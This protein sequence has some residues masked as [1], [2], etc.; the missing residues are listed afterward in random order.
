MFLALLLPLYAASLDNLEIGGPWGTPA[1]TDATAVWWNPAGL[2][3][4]EGTRLMVEVAP[5]IATLSYDRSDPGGGQDTYK[6][7]APV[8][9]AGVATDFGVE[10]LGFG[11]A[12][13][14]PIAR[15]AA[16]QE[17]TGA[18]R[19]ALREGEIKAIYGLVGAG[20]SYKDLVAVGAS[21]AVVQSSWAGVVDSVLLPDLVTEI[22]KLGEETHYT[23]ADI[24]DPDYAATLHLD[25][26]QDRAVTFGGGI[27]VAL[28]PKVA[29]ALSHQRGMS[30]VHEGEVEL[31]FGCP[32]E[33]D[34]IGR[35]GAESYG[36]CDTTLTSD[37][38]VSYRLPGRWH[39]GLQV[40]PFT[41]TTIEGMAGLVRWSVHDD[42][43]IVISGTEDK[44]N[45]E[46]PDTA[47]L[48]NQERL[49]ARDNHD[50]LWMGL[51]AKQGL[52]ERWVVGGRVMYDTSAVPDAAVC[53]NNFDTD[54]WMFSG[55]AA[56]K[57]TRT[58]QFGVSVTQHVLVTRTI[59][60]SAYAV[61]LGEDKAED[62]YFYPQANGTYGGHITRIGVAARAAF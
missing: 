9:F 20:W 7:F 25:G 13:A 15:G 42:L 58:I 36:I 41:Q 16:S 1:A 14:V 40:Q 49:W 61:T 10:G 60:D 11:A 30:L 23:D 47:E 62:R 27:R 19:Y 53:M 28:H 45:L 55:L 5:L 31:E 59:T 48:V 3:A 17:E 32:P 35:F 39:F 51:D 37:A 22:E 44:N 4:G 8:P 26:L 50:S 12:L 52:G 21:V 57:P 43:G 34:T 29:L 33:S 18:G 2:A 46:N 54:T 56:F 24:E 6:A 38:T